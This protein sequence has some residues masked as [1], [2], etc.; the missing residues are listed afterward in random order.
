MGGGGGGGG[1][2]GGE[3]HSGQEDMMGAMHIAILY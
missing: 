3:D 1:T 2:V